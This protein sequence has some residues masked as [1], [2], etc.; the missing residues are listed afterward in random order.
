SSTVHLLCDCQEEIVVF[1]VRDEGIGI[2]LEDQKHLFETFHRASNVG[3]IPGT[4]LG[5]AIVKQ[6]VDLHQG[7]INIQSQVGAGTTFIV[8]LPTNCQQQAEAILLA[9]G[10]A[11]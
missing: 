9:Q 8:K 3:Q 1:E 5:L 4:G 2:P 11:Q 6:S 7:E 10:Y